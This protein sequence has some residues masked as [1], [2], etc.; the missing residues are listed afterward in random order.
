MLGFPVIVVLQVPFVAEGAW[1]LFVGAVV[2]ILLINA[3]GWAIGSRGWSRRIE[4]LLPNAAIVAIWLMTATSGG[5]TGA[6]AVSLLVPLIWF[7]AYAEPGDV[8]VAMVV[9]AT[10]LLLPAQELIPQLPDQGS[11]ALRAA[12]VVL[13]VVILATVRPLVI[14]LRLNAY[15]AERAQHSL[16]TSHA[17][18]AH[19]LRTPLTAI[20]GLATLTLQRL[21]SDDDERALDALVEYA[22]RIAELGWAAEGIIDG[23]LELSRSG[24]RLPSVEPIELEPLVEQVAASV[25][26]IQLELGEMPEAIV[27][28]RSSLERLFRNLL[29]NAA[30]HAVRGTEDPPA[31]VAVTGTTSS[32]G[33]H[34]TISDDGPGFDPLELSTLFEPWRRGDAASEVGRGL[35]LAI[36]AAIVEQHGGDI[37]A[38][39]PHEGG[40]R[41]TFTLSRTPAGA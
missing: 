10:C 4:M 14:Q 5:V 20:C 39:T 18:L 7:V 2:V 11:I 34:I 27:G 22:E 38:S 33:W 25:P 31:T 23:V 28:H 9:T 32:A 6:F 36:A 12:F 13:L 24:Q 3:I 1:P 15:R 21:E 17:A 16:H 26:G 35:G 29:D 19:D 30:R 41:V 8:L 37:S 40:A